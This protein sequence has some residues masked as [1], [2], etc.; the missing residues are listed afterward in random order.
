MSPR[1]R[2]SVLAEK[3]RDLARTSASRSLNSLNC[4]RANATN[5]MLV[6][7]KSSLR[8]GANPLPERLH[9]VSATWKVPVH[10]ACTEAGGLR[11]PFVTEW[12]RR[13][14]DQK[15]FRDVDDV[16]PRMDDLPLTRREITFACMTVILS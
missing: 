8:V 15:I 1:A 9:Q 11:N 12:F 13:R 6:G 4:V 10:R 7:R 2:S 14:L 5:P 3:D 16:F